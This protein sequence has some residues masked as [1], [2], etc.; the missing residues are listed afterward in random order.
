MYLCVCV[1]VDSVMSDSAMLRT[2]ALQAPLS[3]GFSRQEYWIAFQCPLPENLPNPAIKPMS[4][5]S[6]SVAG[7]FFTISAIW[8]AAYVLTDDP[9]WFKTHTCFLRGNRTISSTTC[10]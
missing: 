7:G 10:I 2:V 9:K 4:L 3:M 1:Q 6:P 8:E 5:T